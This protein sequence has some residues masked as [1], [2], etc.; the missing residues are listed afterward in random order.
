MQAVAQKK[1]D[2]ETGKRSRPFQLF[3][4]PDN[5]D[6]ITFQKRVPDPDRK[7]NARGSSAQYVSSQHRR[8]RLTYWRRTKNKAPGILRDFAVIT[9]SIPAELFYKRVI[10]ALVP[11]HASIGYH[12]AASAY[13][14]SCTRA[15]GVGINEGFFCRSIAIGGTLQAKDTKSPLQASAR[16]G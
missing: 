15:V 16:G 6:I 7:A 11:S 4:T 9:S 14:S 13:G 8:S 1:L 3:G 5:M 12:R 2:D 10:F